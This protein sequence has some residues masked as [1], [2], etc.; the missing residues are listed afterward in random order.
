MSVCHHNETMKNRLTVF[1]LLMLASCQFGITQSP[2]GAHIF[3][4]YCSSKM[5]MWQDGLQTVLLDTSLNISSFGDD[6]SGGIYVVGHTGAIFR[7]AGVRGITASRT[8]FSLA[9]R[10]AVSLTAGGG[11]ADLNVGYARV[12]AD[13][14]HVLPGGLAIYGLRNSGVLV[15][16]AT[17]PISPLRWSGRI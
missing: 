4:D 12:Q 2:Y 16:E 17:V 5:F 14:G 7:I 8:G 13:S 9:D 6:L 10:A 11:L 1:V 3:G 15:S